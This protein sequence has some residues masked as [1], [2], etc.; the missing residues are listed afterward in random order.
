MTA[1]PE[2]LVP[3]GGVAPARP[4]VPRRLRCLRG[5]LGRYCVPLA[6]SGLPVSYRTAQLVGRW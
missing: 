4:P 3:P 5:L 6:D 2:P 1:Y